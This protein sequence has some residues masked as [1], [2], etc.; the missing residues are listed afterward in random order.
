MKKNF[1]VIQI[2]GFKGI[3]LLIGAA[4]C[5]AAG[6][7]AFPGFV[8]KTLWNIL[9]SYTSVIPPIGIIQ[10]VLLWGIIVV[11]YFAFRKKGYFVEFK[12][13]DDLSREEMD[14]VIQRIRMERQ[15]DIIAKSILRAK[16]LEEKARKELE[17]DNSE[18]KQD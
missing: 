1:N 10:G 15:S 2:N 16:E 6:F 8:M 13:A 3:L 12:S 5:L 17:K 14:A 7:I 9:A 4:M 11:S 18:I